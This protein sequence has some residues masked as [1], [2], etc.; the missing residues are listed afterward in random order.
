MFSP[1]TCGVGVLSAAGTPNFVSSIYL[2]KRLLVQ[3]NLTKKETPYEKNGEKKIATAFFVECGDEQID[4][5]VVYH[6]GKNGEPDKTYT[7]RKAILSAFATPISPK[8]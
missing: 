7:T 2:G 3:V 6:K 5:Q 1:C 4:V 8:E